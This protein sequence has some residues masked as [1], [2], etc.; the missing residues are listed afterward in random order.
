MLS[1][2]FL[3][4]LTSIPLFYSMQYKVNSGRVWSGNEKTN[5][6]RVYRKSSDYTW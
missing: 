6:R 2:F 1:F 3:F 5:N 4:L